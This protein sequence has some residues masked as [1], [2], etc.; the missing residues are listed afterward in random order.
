METKDYYKKY[1][2]YKLKY[3]ELK[4]SY[5]GDG[6]KTKK[7]SCASHTTQEE[8]LKNKKRLVKNPQEEVTRCKFENGKC[9]ANNLSIDKDKAINICKAANIQNCYN[10]ET[11][12]CSK[13]NRINSDG[14]RT[15]VLNDSK[16]RE[17]NTSV[18]EAHPRETCKFNKTKDDCLRKKADV[19]D[20]YG[21]VLENT[22]ACNWNQNKCIFNEKTSEIFISE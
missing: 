11:P 8:C 21:K 20:Q 22:T 18:L 5:G 1:L 7:I 15:C 6:K 9:S 10:K 13:P 19:I 3:L 2:K 4:K 17:Y 12:F 16:L 14:S